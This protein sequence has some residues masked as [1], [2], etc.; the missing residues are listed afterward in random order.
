MS[1]ATDNPINR[2]VGN[3]FGE[4]GGADPREARAKASPAWCVRGAL[5]RIAACPELNLDRGAG[6]LMQQIRTKVFKGKMNG[7]EILAAQKFIQ[8]MQNYKAMESVTNDISGKQ[9]ER[10]L[11]AKVTLADLVNGSYEDLGSS[12]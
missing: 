10:V 3:R 9:V 6:S 11:E 2:L 12:E 1:E 8:A 4:A 7:G 5:R